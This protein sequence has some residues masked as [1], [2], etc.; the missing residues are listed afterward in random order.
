MRYKLS[1]VLI[2]LV[3]ASCAAQGEVRTYRQFKD[4]SV[5]E[6]GNV[7]Q[8]GSEG[9]LF[10]YTYDVDIQSN[11]VTR[12]KVRRLD[13]DMARDDATVYTITGMKKVYGSEA[14]RG[15]KV[16]VAV[17]KDGSEILELGGKFAFNT[18]TSPFSQVITGVY[19]R[20]YTEQDHKKMPHKKPS[21]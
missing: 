2:A 12:I 8:S 14:G 3:V 21:F 20:I 7:R 10:E 19:K 18:R 15:G 1:M 13:E 17:S 9:D 16:I 4:V 6:G 11:K 5:R